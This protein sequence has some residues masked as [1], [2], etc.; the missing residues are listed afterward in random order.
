MSQKNNNEEETES[1]QSWYLKALRK[2]LKKRKYSAVKTK[3][4][5]Q[6]ISETTWEDSGYIDD[7]IRLEHFILEGPHSFSEGMFYGKLR[8]DYP[9]EWEA[10]Y[11]ELDP[12]QLDSLL[13]SEAKDREL[14]KRLDKEE[15]LL[16]QRRLEFLKLDWKKAG[17]KGGK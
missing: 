17:G 6:K 2:D 1:L 4:V 11:R 12:K 9:K 14:E 7:L 10:I 3:Y 13:A 5:E 15:D 16:D 8:S